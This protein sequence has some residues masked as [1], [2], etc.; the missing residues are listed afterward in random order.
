LITFRGQIKVKKQSRKS[1]I[2]HPVWQIRRK[3][4]KKKKFSRD[5]AGA[6]HIQLHPAV[7]LAL[8]FHKKNTPLLP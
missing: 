8:N 6:P 3:T 5:F 7:D 2:L 4:L 1:K